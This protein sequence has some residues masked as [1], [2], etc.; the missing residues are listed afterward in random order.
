MATL[1]Y[2]SVLSMLKRLAEFV[3]FTIVAMV[4]GIVVLTVMNRNTNSSRVPVVPQPVASLV[5]ADELN[6]VSQDS[7]DGKMTVTMNKLTVKS[8]TTYSFYIAKKRLFS[9]ILGSSARM[10]IPYN[11]WSPDDVY[12]FLKEDDKNV[13]SY[14]VFKA[15]GASFTNQLAYIDISDLFTSRYPQYI[16]TEVTG[17]AAP[18]LLIINTMGEDG[19][20]GPS[21]WFDIPSQSFIQLSTHFW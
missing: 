11:T 20:I 4:I 21:F 12:L 6:V 5:A 18:D 17:W 7:P 14:Y 8:E 13:S 2:E 10:S 16:L 19:K 9:K 3:G 15:S 1:L